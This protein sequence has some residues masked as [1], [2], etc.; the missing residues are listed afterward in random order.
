MLFDFRIFAVFYRQYDFI[1]FNSLHSLRKRLLLLDQQIQTKINTN[2]TT[3]SE[4]ITDK[5]KFRTACDDDL[6]YA[7]Q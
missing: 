1:F 2:Q 6:Y 5:A 3:Y 4:R 7:I